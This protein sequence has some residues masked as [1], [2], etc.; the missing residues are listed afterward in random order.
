MIPHD[1]LRHIKGITLDL[2]VVSLIFVSLL[3]LYPMTLRF[4]RES[5]LCNNNFSVKNAARFQTN[6]KNTKRHYKVI[7]YVF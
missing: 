4:Y 6:Y 1:M 7:I 5:C 2:C 3:L